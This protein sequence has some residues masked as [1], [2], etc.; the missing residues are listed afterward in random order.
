MEEDCAANTIVAYRNDLQ[1]LREYL[2]HAAAESSWVD[3]T[4]D[5]IQSYVQYLWSRDYAA[6]TVARKVSA[7][8]S[9]FR[10]LFDQHLVHSDPLATIG[11]PRVDRPRPESLSQEAVARLLALAARD[12]MPPSLRDR[13]LLELL[14]ATGLK[15]S[16]VVMLEVEDVS[17]ASSTVRCLSRGGE[18]LI[19]LPPRTKE[20]LEAYLTRGRLHFLQDREE[21]ALFLNYRGQR[22][23]RQGLWLRVQRYAREAGLGDGVNP[24]AL[25]HSFA[26][27]LLSEGVEMTEVQELLGHASLHTTRVYDQRQEKPD[28]SQQ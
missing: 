4:P 18:R 25:R 16:E 12:A 8:R 26:A 22:L 28:A 15:A 20:A 11:T 13:A 17:L 19:P 6:S 23:S 2:T 7:L 1:Q 9:F 21:G 10:F 14:Y 5:A 3:V 27:H 24:Q